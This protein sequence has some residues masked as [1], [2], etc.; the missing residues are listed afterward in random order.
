MTPRITYYL[1]SW[2]ARPSTISLRFVSK[3]GGAWGSVAWRGLGSLAWM[4][5]ARVRAS[6]TSWGRWGLLRSE[7]R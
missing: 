2:A 4:R 3:R 1:P 7:Q 5:D 6:A